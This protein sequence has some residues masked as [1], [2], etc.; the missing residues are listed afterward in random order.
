MIMPDTVYE[1]YGQDTVSRYRRRSKGKCRYCCSG[2][3]D[4]SIRPS[5]AIMYAL[6]LPGLGQAYNR[7]YYKMPIVWA[8]LGVRAMP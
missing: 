3:P 4:L 1:I 6:V 2:T 7:K 5:R 8:A